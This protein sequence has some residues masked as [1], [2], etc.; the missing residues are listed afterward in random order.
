MTQLPIKPE[1]ILE[2][3]PAGTGSHKQKF[4]QDVQSYAE[5]LGY[6][7]CLEQYSANCCN[8]VIGN[9]QNARYLLTSGRALSGLAAWLEI[10]RT[11]PENQRDKVCFLLLDGKSR[12][13]R[14]HKKYR[15]EMENRLVIDL[16]HV[17][18]GEHL[19]IYPSRKLKENRV[20]LT[21]FYRICGYFGN[22]DMLVADGKRPILLKSFSCFPYCA[23]VCALQS[24][25]KRLRYHHSSRHTALDN[26]NVNILRAALTTFICRDEVN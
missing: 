9:V 13:F 7:A 20:R 23:T 14:F 4:L 12:A 6:A 16:N 21:S 2:Q 15:E 5:S 17:G 25:K 8:L 22:R 11:F 24:H 19:R 26:T 10:L 18:D 3:Y 1:D